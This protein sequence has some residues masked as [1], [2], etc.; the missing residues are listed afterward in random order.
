MM[1]I[2]LLIYITA[3]SAVIYNI[4]K[5]KL[6]AVL[7]CIERMLMRL[8]QPISEVKKVYFKV[9]MKKVKAE[10]KWV[11]LKE[12]KLNKVLLTLICRIK[13][14]IKSKKVLNNTKNICLNVA[15]SD[16]KRLYY[17]KKRLFDNYRAICEQAEEYDFLFSLETKIESK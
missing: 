7:K 8:S 14:P 2:K 16:A 9:A 10:E 15:I 17:N 12:C 5:D 4:L 3:Y 11:F 1:E 13:L 6:K